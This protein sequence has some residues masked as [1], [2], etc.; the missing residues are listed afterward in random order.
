VPRRTM[1]VV[2]IG[3]GGVAR[4]IVDMLRALASCGERVQWND[5]IR[6]IRRTETRDDD[7]LLIGAMTSKTMCWNVK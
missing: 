6:A 7:W 5:A 3:L 4:A 2:V 1:R